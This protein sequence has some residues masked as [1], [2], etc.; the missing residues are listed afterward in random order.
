MNV[1]LRDAIDDGTVIGPLMRVAGAYI[2][3]STGGGELA[4]AAP[5]VALPLAYR[6]GVANSADQV[7][8]RCGR[9]STAARTSSR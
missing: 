6:F 1:G 3:V 9:C 2:T 5:D 7:R 4:G 8:E